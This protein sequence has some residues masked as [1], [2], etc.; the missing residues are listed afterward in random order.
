MGARDEQGTGRG[1]RGRDR[2][3]GRPS[4]GRDRGGRPPPGNAVWVERQRR[5]GHQ[6]ALGREQIVRAAVALADAEGPEAVSMRRLAAA[7][8]AGAMSLYWHV[9]DKE[10]LLD[11]MFDHVFGELDLPARPSGD[12]RADVRR[13]AVET[14]RVF[15]RHPWLITVAAGRT[16]LG[17]N[18]LDHAEFSIAAVEGL[19]VPAALWLSIPAVVDD[20]VLGSVVRMQEM[21]DRQQQG[22]GPEAEWEA[23][24]AAHTAAEGA[25]GRYPTLARL[26]GSE[27]TEMGEEERFL[28]GLDCLLD[29]IATRVDAAS[30]GAD[31]G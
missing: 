11:L 26:I 19:P 17:P 4:R 20:Y 9:P 14:R 13:V 1:P 24:V 6:P 31:A 28:L 29:G 27:L 5:R 12:W 25:E 8:G 10:A 21:A 23:A 7:L 2:E 3:T 22:E 15:L 30:N 16:P 18:F